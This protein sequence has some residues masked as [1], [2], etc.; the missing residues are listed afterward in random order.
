MSDQNE[1]LARLAQQREL[2][3]RAAA[4]DEEAWKSAM[5]ALERKMKAGDLAPEDLQRKLIKESAGGDIFY[6]GIAEADEASWRKWRD[7]LPRRRERIDRC[8]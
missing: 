8:K 1:A 6:Q 3:G 4:G 7:N 2:E 5:G